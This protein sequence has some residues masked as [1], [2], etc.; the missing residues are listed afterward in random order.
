MRFYFS[1]V[2]RNAEQA[3]LEKAGV[4]RIL[5]DPTQYARLN[6]GADQFSIALDS[7]AYRIWKAKGESSLTAYMMAVEGYQGK[8]AVFDFVTSLDDMESWEATRQNF[9][10]WREMCEVPVVP[11]WHYGEPTDL[12]TEYLDL[13][14][15]VG[16]GGLVPHLFTKAPK[17]QKEE[18]RK[19]VI[20]LCAAYPHRLRLFGACDISLLNAV[21][22]SAL[23]ADSSLWLRGQ[24]RGAYIHVNER[25]GKLQQL[26]KWLMKR[27]SEDYPDIG[28]ALEMSGRDRSIANARNLEEYLN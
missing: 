20:A 3:Q 13:S 25:N 23:S 8:G 22:D 7:G 17:E 10:D 26:N 4:S 24:R 16:I 18:C 9:L 21:K 12:L 27:L 5:V 28:S 6:G 19:V 11:V 15:E 14:P 2:E 1:G